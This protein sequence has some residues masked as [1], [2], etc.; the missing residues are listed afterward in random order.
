MAYQLCPKASQLTPYDPA[1]GKYRVRLDANESFLLPTEE[2]RGKMGRAAAEVALNRYPDPLARDLCGAFAK[3]Y[4]ISPDLVTAGNGSDELISLILSTFLQKGEKVLTLSPDFSMYRFY[5]AISETPC[6]VLE[7]GKGFRIN[8]DVVLDTIR[9][10]N[11]RLLIFSNP[12]NPTSV[13][14]QASEVRRLLQGTDALV[15]L[16]E[17]YMDFWD[18]SL[19]PEVAE[20]DNLILLRTCS[21]AIGLAALRIGFA[22]ANPCLT[23]VIRAAK[24]PYNVNAVSQEM[25]RII[26]E[27]DQYTTAYSELIRTS[28]DMLLTGLKKLEGEGALQMV[29]DSCTNFAYIQ[30]EDAR[31]VYERLADSGIIVRCFGDHF[32][33]ISAGTQAENSELLASL[34]FLLKYRREHP[35]G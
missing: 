20:Y 24:S 1:E 15:V 10:E 14:L 34:R 25:A 30:L 28:R 16:D 8:V 2:D 6:I 3:R 29:C 9:K 27:N 19:L 31:W 7:K 33:R 35:N 17:A 23:A 32:L 22:V 11:V 5:T 21:K 13:G 26:L 12:C 4:S 18:Q